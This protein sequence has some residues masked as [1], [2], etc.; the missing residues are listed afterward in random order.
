MLLIE[1]G[2]NKT[3]FNQVFNFLLQHLSNTTT[4]SVNQNVDMFQAVGHPDILGR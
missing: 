3:T 4:N 1:Q 2:K